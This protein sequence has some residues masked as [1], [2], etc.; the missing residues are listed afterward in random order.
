MGFSS[1]HIKH[2]TIARQFPSFSIHHALLR[3]KTITIN[4]L[5]F[6]CL[7]H[8]KKIP[9]LIIHQLIQRECR[10]IE[11]D[12]NTTDKTAPITTLPK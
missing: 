2:T 6:I 4:L 5:T 10:R 12:R 3:S 9:K 7:N 11:C 8:Q 1:D